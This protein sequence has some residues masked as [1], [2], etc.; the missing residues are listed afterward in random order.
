MSNIYGF[1]K[2][3]FSNIESIYN[4]D[5]AYDRVEPSSGRFWA[6]Y[7]G[8]K[9]II[10]IKSNIDPY[11]NHFLEEMVDTLIETDSL[12]LRLCNKGDEL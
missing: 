8:S 11:D 2:V 3:S 1:G 10:N 7:I 12:I 9:Y 5:L 4:Y 6:G